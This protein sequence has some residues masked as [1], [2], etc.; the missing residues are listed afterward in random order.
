MKRLRVVQPGSGSS[1]W[2]QALKATLPVMFGYVPLGMAFG[3]LFVNQ[4]QHWY[5]AM[6]MAIFVFAGAA[7]FI[8]V[9]LLATGAGLAAIAATTL[10]LNARHV[11]YGL[12][13]A[14]RYP[15]R[16]WQR[17]YLIFGLT[18]ETYSLLSGRPLPPGVDASRF[19]LA[20]TALD[21]FYWVLGCTLGAVVGRHLSIDLSGLDFALTALFVVLLIEQILEVRDWRPFL[22]AVFSAGIASWVAGPD[23]MLLM[24][25]A[26]TTALLWLDPRRRKWSTQYT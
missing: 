2:P 4:V 26:L 25:L 19:Y 6:L 9:S 14:S 12:S 16:G 20:V 18:D 17:G 11:F 15:R 5:L 24:A 8:A 22:L 21:H 23:H 13:L 1:V 3:I 7:Q 10:V